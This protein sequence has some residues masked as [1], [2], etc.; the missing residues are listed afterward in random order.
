[1]LYHSVEQPRQ[2]GA[3]LKRNSWHAESLAGADLG[4]ALSDSNFAT[5]F[6]TRGPGKDGQGFVLDLGSEQTISGAALIPSGFKNG[7]AGF[8]LETAGADRVFARSGGNG[9]YWGPFYFSGPHPFLKARFCRIETYFKPVKARYVRFR[10][11]GPTRYP[12]SL[13]EVLLYG[14]GLEDLPGWEQSWQQAR[15]LLLQR[16]PGASWPTPGPRPR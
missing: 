4:R 8:V 7:P 2:A 1:M 5:G 14:P 15:H 9:E 11:D 12:V 6:S 10:L 16:L 13:P 3:L